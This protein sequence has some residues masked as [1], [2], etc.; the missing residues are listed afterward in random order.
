MK[1]TL[2]N[3]LHWLIRLRCLPPFHSYFP[4]TSLNCLSIV[5]PPCLV[6]PVASLYRHACNDLE[7]KFKQLYACHQETPLIFSVTSQ[8]SD[9][10]STAVQDGR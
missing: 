4:Y 9:C 1:D 5:E 8:I 3:H 6:K 2:E 10:E 7:T